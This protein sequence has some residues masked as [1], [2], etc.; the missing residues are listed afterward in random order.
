METWLQTVLAVFASVLACS[1]FWTYLQTRREQKIKK[2]EKEEEKNSA[3]SRMLLGL[4]HDRIIYLCLKYI[5]R[6]WITKDEYEDLTEYLY[7]PYHDMG[8]NGTA[9]RLMAEV[10]ELPVKHITHLQ[11][12][13]LRGSVRH[14]L[15]RKLL[16]L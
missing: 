13:Q 3:K 12:V 1:G 10:K 4:G 11:H 6:G 14:G 15:L 9:E 7:K 2:Q 8:G 5:E 16:K